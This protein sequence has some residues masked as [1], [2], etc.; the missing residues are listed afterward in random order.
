MKINEDNR[1]DKLLEKKSA[2]NENDMNGKNLFQ[3]YTYHERPQI[4]QIKYDVLAVKQ[5]R[6][7]FHVL[8][9]YNECNIPSYL[10]ITIQKMINIINLP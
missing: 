2:G 10:V 5:F 3:S 7:S 8:S 4:S 9:K 6:I 1:N